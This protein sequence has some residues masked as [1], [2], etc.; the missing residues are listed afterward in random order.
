M[1]PPYGPREYYH[2]L[3]LLRTPQ[4]IILFTSSSNKLQANFSFP[5]PMLQKPT[6]VCSSYPV[7]DY[8]GFLWSA[9]ILAEESDALRFKSEEPTTHMF[10]SENHGL[11]SA[12]SH[13][14]EKYRQSLLIRTV[15]F[16]GK[17]RKPKFHN[18]NR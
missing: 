4:V 12:F 15:T 14:A 5:R 17:I 13:C 8:S 1:L 18:A 16:M 7:L 10:V 3:R 9:Q 2:A 11:Y 6:P